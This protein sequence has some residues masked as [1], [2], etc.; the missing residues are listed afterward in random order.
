MNSNLIEHLTKRAAGLRGLIEAQERAIASSVTIVLNP[1]LT[2]KL[3]QYRKSLRECEARLQSL[4]A[5][6][7]V[8]PVTGMTARDE[9]FVDKLSARQ[10]W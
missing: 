2:R 1:H 4:H 9:A 6:E 3:K 7:P 5:S 8:S 10:G